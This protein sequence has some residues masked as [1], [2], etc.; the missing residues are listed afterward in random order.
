MMRSLSIIAISL[1]F[2]TN[3][4]ASAVK[5]RSFS[6][7]VIFVSEKYI[8]MKRGSKEII[9]YKAETLKVAGKSSD[10]GKTAVEI[11]QYAKAEYVKQN[12]RN[13]LTKLVITA[14]SDCVE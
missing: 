14:E 5:M 10:T 8:E 9:L 3:V 13:V 12:G 6:G 4:S 1:I 11:C 7:R 2:F